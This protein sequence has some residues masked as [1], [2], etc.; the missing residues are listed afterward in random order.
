MSA[1]EVSLAAESTMSVTPQ[2]P[3]LA[4]QISGVIGADPLLLGATGY[5]DEVFPL[6]LQ[7]ST[8]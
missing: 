6:R 3:T 1:P 5:A 7:G 8:Q 4:D 2:W